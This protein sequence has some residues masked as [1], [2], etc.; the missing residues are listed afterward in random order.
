MSKI[1]IRMKNDDHILLQAQ[2]KQL[3]EVEN[4]YY[5][6]PD[7]IDMSQFEVSDRIYNCP[8]KG[9]CFWVDL[10]TDLGWVNDICWV[11]PEAKKAYQQIAGWYGFYPSHKKYEIIGQP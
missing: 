1:T 5:I 11:Y 10:K 7:L 4:N 3:Q 2:G 8:V 9:I 6:H